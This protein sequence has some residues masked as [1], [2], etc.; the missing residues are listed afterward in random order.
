MIKKSNQDQLDER[1]RRAAH[2]ASLIAIKSLEARGTIRNFG[3]FRLL[4]G[5][6]GNIVWGECF[7]LSAEETGT[8]RG[9]KGD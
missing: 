6:H 7:D 3:G 1:A 5:Q 2:K 8:N 9:Q 4:D